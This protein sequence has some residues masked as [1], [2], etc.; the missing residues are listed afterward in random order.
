MANHVATECPKGHPTIIPESRD[1]QGY[2]RECRRE[3]RTTQRAALNVVAIFEA[4]GA[5]FQRDGVPCDPDDVVR[6]LMK[7]YDSGEIK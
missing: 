4:A 2:C 7:L 6:Q 1:A 5:E 3:R